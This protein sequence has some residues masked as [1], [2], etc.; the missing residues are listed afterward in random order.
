[1][2]ND[3]VSAARDTVSEPGAVEDYKR[4][5]ASAA[6]LLVEDEMRV[7]LGT[8]TTTAYLFGALAQRKLR[9]IRCVAS[10]PATERAAEAA[11]LRLTTLAELGGALEITIDGADQIDPDGWLVKGGGGAHAREKILAAAASRFVVIASAEKA[12]TAL[13]PPVP[14]EIMR[15]GAPYTLAALAPSRLREC[16]PSPDGNLIADYLG[17]VEDPARLAARIA[18]TPGVVAHGLF[19]P[20]LVA[21]ILIAGTDGVAH[22]ELSE[23]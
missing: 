9:D 7:G 4:A 22:R 5:A 6:A 19:E 10:S 8:G 13:G 20:A 11:G 14:L 3:H 18:S 12:V 1:L 16:P 23:R 17:P 15:F 2:A 21:D